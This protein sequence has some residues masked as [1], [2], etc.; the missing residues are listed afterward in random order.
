MSGQIVVG[1]DGS[2]SAAAAVEWAA[3]DAGRRKARLKIVHV[4]E[5]WAYDFLLK[6]GL[7]SRDSLPTYWRAV[8]AATAERVRERS[9]GLEVSVA[10]ITGAVSERL[11]TESEYADEIVLGS[12]GRGGLTAMVLGSV[13]RAVTGHACSPVVVVRRFAAT[14]Y[15]EVVVGFDGSAA[16]EAALAYATHQARLRGAR[17]RALHVRTLPLAPFSRRD[18]DPV[19]IAT[20][21]LVAR[22]R[23]WADANPDVPQSHAV[24]RGHPVLALRRASDHADLLVVGSR[25]RPRGS[26][27]LGSVARSVLRH[28]H[29][30]VAVVHP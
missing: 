16:S 14:T 1:V 10:L 28:A 9:P 21:E 25:T 2:R 27:H 4:R 8:L 20:A 23:P 29:C 6:P 22:L 30:P 7:R 11:T 17:L 3:A 24:I 18:R 12:E 5:P 13:G 26:P 19:T 15:G